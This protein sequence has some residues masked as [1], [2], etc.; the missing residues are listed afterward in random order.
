MYGYGYSPF[1]KSAPAATGNAPVNTV[2]PAITGTAQQGKT[3]TC[4]QGTWTGTPTITYTYQWKR[5]G[6]PIIGAS[7]FSY[8]LVD[9][10]INQSIKC[11][12]TATNIEGNTRADSNTVTPT[13]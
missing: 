12:V 10:D 3:L 4:S 7:N 8:L 5:N 2:A 13:S 9:A 6:A 1:V 11:T